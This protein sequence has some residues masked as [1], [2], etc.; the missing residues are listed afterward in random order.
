M[1]NE[2]TLMLEHNDL[3]RDIIKA[4]SNDD[5]CKE[6]ISN[7]HENNNN[8]LKLHSKNGT[9]MQA[10][11]IYIPRNNRHI[12]TN[13][14]QQFH[15]SKCH[16][17]TDKTTI[18]IKRQYYWHRMDKDIEEYIRT[19]M[20]CMQTKPLLT[21][22]QGLLQSHKIPSYPWQVIS[23]DFITGLPLSHNNNDCIAV[24]VD[25]FSKMVHILPMKTTYT[26]EQ[27]ADLFK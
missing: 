11:R 14:L 9:I 5:L 27:F 23:I 19:C 25:M 17:G 15:D 26:T 10:D 20:K 13:I 21:R 16:I 2:V 24:I 8:R 18:A 12:I 6:I 22:T 7:N 3:Y 4:Q 1:L